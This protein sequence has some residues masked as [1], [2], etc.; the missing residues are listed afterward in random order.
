MRR[1]IR[2][3]LGLKDNIRGSVAVET[4]LI[5]AMLSTFGVGVADYGMVYLRSM[6]LSNAVRAGV[7]YA[8]VRHPEN[9]GTYSNVISAVS[10]ALA[11]STASANQTISVDLYCR[12]PDGSASNCQSA[13][14]VDITCADGSTREAYVSIAVEEDHT[15]MFGYPA[16]ADVLHLSQNAIVRL[17]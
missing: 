13:G 3:C 16:I 2:K 7:Q 10:G 5:M 4:A 9:G 17:N 14:G 1:F 6:E 11:T 8:T 15:L 12:C